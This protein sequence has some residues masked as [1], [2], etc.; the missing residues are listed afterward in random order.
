MVGYGWT[1]KY[2][3]TQNTFR[4]VS[5]FG[6]G[7][8]SF[9]HLLGSIFLLQKLG[10]LLF[11]SNVFNEGWSTCLQLGHVDFYPNGG[12]G[13]QP[14]CESEDPLGLDCSHER[15]PVSLQ[16]LRNICS[17]QEWAISE[18]VSKSMNLQLFLKNMHLIRYANYILTKVFLSNA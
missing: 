6:T 14:G 7:T 18:T 5:T 2:E 16:I 13:P 10:W 12:Q 3:N 15:A 1:R 11:A 4:K 8:K 17:L 9:Y